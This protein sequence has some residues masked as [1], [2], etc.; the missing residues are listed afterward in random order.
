M[1]QTI[2]IIMADHN[3]RTTTHDLLSPLSANIYA[4]SS[5]EAFLERYRHELGCLLLD[6][7]LPGMSGLKC[8][9]TIL[10]RH[11]PLS[12]LYLSEEPDVATVVEAMKLGAYDFIT[13][14]FIHY[15]LY[16]KVH[17]LL[18]KN[19]QQSHLDK[20]RDSIL[21]KYNSLTPREK[22]VLNFMVKGHA[23]KKIATEMGISPNT[24]QLHKANIKQ[25][26]Q[27]TGFNELLSLLFKFGII[28]ELELL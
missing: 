14:P 12:V 8:H 13:T 22:E 2:F 21:E 18:E 27:V 26:M 24:V 28:E 11:Y 19:L 3:M 4:F 1:D 9:K 5:A 20:N 7:R 10:K 25:K 23:N 15:Q 16:D 17:T 6:V